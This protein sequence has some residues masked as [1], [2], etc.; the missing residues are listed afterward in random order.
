MI[1]FNSWDDEFDD[2]WDENKLL[3]EIIEDISYNRSNWLLYDPEK[4]NYDPFL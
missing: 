1:V 3:S 4:D 2:D